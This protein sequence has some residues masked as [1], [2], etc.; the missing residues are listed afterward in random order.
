MVHM[1]SYGM[2]VSFYKCGVPGEGVGHVAH[3][4]ISKCVECSQVQ[5][6]HQARRH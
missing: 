3:V 2:Y 6:V 5:C 1:E 4:G